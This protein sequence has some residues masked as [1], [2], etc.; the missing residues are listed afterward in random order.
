MK[1]GR[2]AQKV[3][4][5]SG[6][7]SGIGKATCLRLA[8]EGAAV[9]VVDMNAAHAGATAQ[10]IAGAGGRSLAMTADVSRSADVQR[11]LSATRDAWGQLDVIVNDAAT[12]TFT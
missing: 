1:D 5:V 9:A 7:G 12:M 6:G 2:F 11:A 4:L 10:E 8:Q 3:C